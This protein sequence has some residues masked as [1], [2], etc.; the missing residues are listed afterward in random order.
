VEAFPKHWG[1]IVC[2]SRLDQAFGEGCLLGSVPRRRVALPGGP[3]GE[4][5]VDADDIADVVVAVLTDDGHA[6]RIYEASGP[7]EVS[8]AEAVEELAAATGR[9]IRYMRASTERY[10]AL[11]AGQDVPEEV[12]VRLR[13]VMDELVDGRNGAADPASSAPSAA[14]RATSA[15]TRGRP[16]P[17]ASGTRHR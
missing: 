7:R 9:R 8:F 12:V 13:R 14:S 16:S 5:F 17:A 3:V 15:T 1:P 10:A 4:P 11:L 6:R 2:A